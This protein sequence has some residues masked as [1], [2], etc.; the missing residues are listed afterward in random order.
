MTSYV[1]C[2]Q[3]VQVIFTSVGF[4]FSVVHVVYHLVYQIEWVTASRAFVI[5]PAQELYVGF[6]GSCV[7][8]EAVGSVFEVSVVGGLGSFDR[9]ILTY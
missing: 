2:L 3:V 9:Q 4:S 5:L 8:T 1:N 6:V 7:C